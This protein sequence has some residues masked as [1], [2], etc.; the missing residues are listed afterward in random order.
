MLTKK[1][2]DKESFVH[3]HREARFHL[4]FFSSLLSLHVGV[5]FEEQAKMMMMNLV[6]SP[7]GASSA[8]ALRGAAA[9]S[10]RMWSLGS[11]VRV[12]SSVRGPIVAF[13]AGLEKKSRSAV[14]CAAR[15]KPLHAG[16]LRGDR[17]RREAVA[18]RSKTM[19]STPPAPPGAQPITTCLPGIRRSFLGVS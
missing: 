13:G 18:V 12:G 4:Y 1:K 19:P 8:V 11:T 15:T 3:L 10:S 5:D 7:L 6:A 17:T 9:P 14:L 2:K 16:S